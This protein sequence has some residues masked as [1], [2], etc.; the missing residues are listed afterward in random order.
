MLDTL[1]QLAADAVLNVSWD[2]WKQLSN[3]AT[4]E[5]EKRK[6]SVRQLFYPDYTI[7]KCI[8]SCTERRP[9]FLGIL[10]DAGYWKMYQRILE[11]QGLEFLKI[12][13]LM[14]LSLKKAETLH[15]V[16]R[17][18]VAWVDAAGERVKVDK[19]DRD[20]P[21]LRKRLVPWLKHF[22]CMLI[23][24]CGS[25]LRARITKVS[26][27]SEAETASMMLQQEVLEF[28]LDNLEGF[29]AKTTVGYLRSGLDDADD[30]D[31]TSSMEY[32]RRFRD[33]GW[34]GVLK[35]VRWY[36]GAD[37]KAEWSVVEDGSSQGRKIDDGIVKFV[38]G[39]CRQIGDAGFFAQDGILTGKIGS[40]DFKKKLV[41][42]VLDQCKENGQNDQEDMASSGKI[43][44]RATQVS[45]LDGYQD[46]EAE[47]DDDSLCDEEINEWH[48]QAT[49]K[50][51]HGP[52]AEASKTSDGPRLTKPAEPPS[53]QW[54]GL[55]W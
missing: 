16:M 19:R 8:D 3:K 23:E 45:A 50:E 34:A 47:A 53:A 20:K 24:M 46:A 10:D 4:G 6:E 43:A 26:E 30:A 52:E 13:R 44:T 35:I 22:D 42:F 32:G 31:G 28:V 38:N 29:M 15:H 48:N 21:A 17:H 51:S 41:D 18:V 55:G 11:G 12:S 27:R 7:E 49:A 25:R 1:S 14:R 39:F 5:G 37:F 54:P 40:D 33:G 9:G 2:D 36:I